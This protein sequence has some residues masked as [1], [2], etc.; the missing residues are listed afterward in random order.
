MRLSPSFELIPICLS[1]LSTRP[2]SSRIEL[3]LIG[4]QCY[5]K[6]SDRHPSRARRSRRAPQTMTW[7]SGYWN[8]STADARRC[9]RST[10]LKTPSPSLSALAM[11]PRQNR[12][13]LCGVES[14]RSGASSFVLPFLPR[15]VPYY[16]G[17]SVF[18]LAASPRMAM[19]HALSNWDE[20]RVFLKEV[21]GVSGYCSHPCLDGF[22][23]HMLSILTWWFDR[24]GHNLG[25]VEMRH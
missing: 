21:L 22:N 2:F 14:W 8:H 15:S 17:G 6:D 24:V 18:V 9:L 13:M 7:T 16:G 25:D 11:R 10:A 1:K 5:D 20:V 12:F 23:V 19:Y 3:S 4:E